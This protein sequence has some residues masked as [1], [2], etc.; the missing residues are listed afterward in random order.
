MLMLK[1]LQKTKCN[2]LCFR[3]NTPKIFRPK[4]HYLFIQSS[5]TKLSESNP[6]DT[7]DDDDNDDDDDDEK[8][9]SQDVDPERL[10][11]FNVSENVFC[12]FYFLQA[13]IVRCSCYLV[14][15]NI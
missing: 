2:T 15:W 6:D 8:L 5:V 10:K 12:I 4:Y 11:A 1:T 3:Y 7:K 9:A 14:S 13:C